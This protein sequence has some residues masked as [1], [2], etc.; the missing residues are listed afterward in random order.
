MLFLVKEL[1]VSTMFSYQEKNNNL[2]LQYS[3]TSP[4]NT[5]TN[6]PNTG[7]MIIDGSGWSSSGSSLNYLDK[8]TP[9]SLFLFIIIIIFSLPLY[10]QPWNI[11]RLTVSWIP[12]SATTGVGPVRRRRERPRRAGVSKLSFRNS[13]A[14]ALFNKWAR[15]CIQTVYLCCNERL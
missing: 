3:K 5:V 12:P 9:M 2:V 6:S 15:Q 14:A 8:L 1:Y 10:E 13:V 11:T 7:S 4:V